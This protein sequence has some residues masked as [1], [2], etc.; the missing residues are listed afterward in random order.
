[1]NEAE[2]AGASGALYDGA[3]PFYSKRIS[4]APDSSRTITGLVALLLEL[5]PNCSLGILQ[6]QGE[7]LEDSKAIVPIRIL[8]HIGSGRV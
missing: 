2:G 3:V 8:L 7:A 6:T 4:D 1:M 5:E